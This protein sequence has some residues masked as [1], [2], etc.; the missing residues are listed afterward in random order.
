MQIHFE[1]LL[2]LLYNDKEY[3]AESI[4]ALRHYIKDDQV[5]LARFG[6]IP[7]FKSDSILN[8]ITGTTKSR[9]VDKLFIEQTLHLIRLYWLSF[10]IL[11]YMRHLYNCNELF[12]MDTGKF[13]QENIY[14]DDGSHPSFI[15]FMDRAQN[16]RLDIGS[17]AC[18]LYM[19]QHGMSCAPVR[20]LMAHKLG[21]H[22]QSYVQSG[23][24]V[25]TK[26]ESFN[27]LAVNSD[28]LWI[29]NRRLY[30]VAVNEEYHDLV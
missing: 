2:N 29:E 1:Q 9:N 8:K 12:A 4:D 11:T 24:H 21:I 14:V 3:V 7:N 18:Q 19:E 17:E 16:Q 20:Y 6:E 22:Y 15:R 13:K 27:G 23:Y 25:L 30:G 26:K 28:I 10:R 5:L